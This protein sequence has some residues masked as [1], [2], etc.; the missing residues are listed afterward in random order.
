MTRLV[1][2]KHTCLFVGEEVPSTASCPFNECGAQAAKR[3]GGRGPWRVRVRQVRQVRHGTSRGVT[4]PLRRSFVL[5]TL[6]EARVCS[7]LGA[8]RTTMRRVTPTCVNLRG[9]LQ[10]FGRLL[11]LLQ[12]CED[13]H[14]FLNGRD[15]PTT[16][17]GVQAQEAGKGWRHLRG[18]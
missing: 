10:S 17:G 14:P 7:P 9:L 3:A 15:D 11:S 12:S 6:V 16:S 8:T 13:R 2:S 5:H 18:E 4:C 1:V